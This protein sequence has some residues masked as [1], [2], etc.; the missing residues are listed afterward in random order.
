MAEASIRN[1]DEQN[2]TIEQTT[3]ML[4]QYPWP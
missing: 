2:P 4:R 1:L 3:A